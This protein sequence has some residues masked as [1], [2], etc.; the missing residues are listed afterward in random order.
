MMRRRDLGIGIGIVVGAALADCVSVPSGGGWP[1]L[2]DGDKG[3]ENWDRIGEA[4]WR[5]GGGAIVADQ[6]KGGYLVSQAS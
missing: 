3:L 2:F 5:A 4:N 6:G 1:T